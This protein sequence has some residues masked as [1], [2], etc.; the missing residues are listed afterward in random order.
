MYDG[1]IEFFS[2]NDKAVSL[3]NFHARD[4]INLQTPCK[5]FDHTTRADCCSSAAGLG[6]SEVIQMETETDLPRTGSQ[7][8]FALFSSSSP[9]MWP[10][11]RPAT[12]RELDTAKC[13]LIKIIPSSSSACH[14]T[15]G[16]K[17]AWS[18]TSAVRWMISHTLNLLC[19]FA[20]V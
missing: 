1:C 14:S 16:Q 6:P 13:L 2:F 5:R 20:R 9:D 4:K 15:L 3:Y 19:E 12:M 11:W 18:H 17:T 8:L 10:Q 7:T